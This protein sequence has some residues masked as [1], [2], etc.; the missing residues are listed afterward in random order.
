[1]LHPEWH[2]VDRV[3]ECERDF[4]RGLAQAC[5][6]MTVSHAV[7]REVIGV[8]GWPPGQVTCVYNGV[9][10][11]LGP[12]PAAEVRRALESCGLEPGY[13]LFVGTLEPRKN[14]MTL[15]RAY[16]D[17]PARLRERAPLVLAGRWGWRADDLA[18]Y[19]DD[20]GRRH[21]VIHLGYFPEKSLHALYAG[22]RALVFP[23]LYEGF[24]LPLVEM[25]ACGGAVI[26]S[27]AT[28]VAE[29]LAGSNAHLVESLDQAGWRAALFRVIA[30]DDWR[31]ELC[32]G[33][34]QA[35]LA[36]TWERCAADTMAVYRTAL[37]HS[38][39]R[40]AA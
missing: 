16:C 10:A 29:V 15:L 11:G 32:H 28:A 40:A 17:L 20:V 36:F 34:E 24:G 2:P 39:Q 22:A 38:V 5:H 6:I 14:I 23:S 12:L 31:N 3:H 37:G 33:A 35:A 9:R 8:L 4:R 19:L 21:G 25:L 30:D 1:L 27:T 26:A 13:L 18:A 7:R